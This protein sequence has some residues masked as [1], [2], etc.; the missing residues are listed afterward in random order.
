[1]TDETRT[2][3]ESGAT[4]A[5]PQPD[6]GAEGEDKG[7]KLH[8][9]VEM[10]DIGPCKKHIKVTIDRVD[11]DK[12]LNDKYSELRVDANVPGFRPGKAP[13]KIIEKRFSKE[14]GDQ[15]KGEVMYQSLEQL[16]E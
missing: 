8:Q 6:A 10:E 12:R 14:V 15:V 9:T 2:D 4:V 11:I 3:P 1:M 5:E 7:K 16:A 13:R